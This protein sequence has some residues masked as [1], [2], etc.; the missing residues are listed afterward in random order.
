M[1]FC[2]TV[3]WRGVVVYSILGLSGAGCW[4]GEGGTAVERERRFHYG[5]GAEQQAGLLLP[6]WG[7]GGAKE[8]RAVVV[9]IHGG[10]LVRSD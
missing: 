10:L 3:V 1:R 6:A 4:R 5:P 7:T 2:F 9:L 8:L